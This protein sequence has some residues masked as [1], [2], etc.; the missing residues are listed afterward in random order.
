ME[1]CA[2]KG[3]KSKQSDIE[4]L[5][6]PVCEKCW[7]KFSEKPVNVLRAA[8]GLKLQDEV[9]VKDEVVE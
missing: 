6:K 8:L 1:K 3:C 5:G 2:I 4:Y 7:A 9:V